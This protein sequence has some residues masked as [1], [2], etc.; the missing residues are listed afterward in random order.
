[1]E[2]LANSID[3]SYVPPEYMFSP[4]NVM[5]TVTYQADKLTSYTFPSSAVQVG[6]H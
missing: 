2:E 4:F 3:M 1:M 6:C 5:Q